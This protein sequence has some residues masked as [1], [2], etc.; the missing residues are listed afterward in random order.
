MASLALAHVGRSG[1]HRAP[2]PALEGSVN[3]LRDACH[4]TRFRTREPG[5]LRRLGRGA[6][7]CAPR[8]T[9]Q[10]A[11]VS[12]LTAGGW[13]LFQPA[14]ASA[15]WSITWRS[16][17]AWIASTRSVSSVVYSSSAPAGTSE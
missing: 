10:V 17:Q 2:E 8:L 13:L 6:R 16:N 4:V 1:L 7:S 15:P 12:A 11:I 14:S 5:R 9:R 3:W